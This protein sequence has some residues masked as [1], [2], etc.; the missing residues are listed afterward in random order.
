MKISFNWIKKYLQQTDITPQ[1]LSD[2]IKLHLSDIESFE[3][4]HEKYKNLLIGEIVKKQEHPNADKLGVYE[5]KIG[6][7]KAVQVVAGDK[8]LKVGD[9]VVYL[10]PKT[11]VPYNAYP[12]R[13]DG[14]IQKAKLRGIESNGMLASEK[15]LGISSDHDR[16]MTL[17]LECKAGQDVANVLGLN[18]YIFEVENKTLTIRPDTFGLIG[19]SRDISGFLNLPFTTPDWLN[20]PS[21]IKPKE[22]KKEK[23]PLKILN[24]TQR[25]CP[26]YMAITMSDVQ[27]KPSPLWLKIFLSSL[28]IKPINNVVDITNYLMVLT[29]QPLHAFDY[30]KVIS[31]DL[32]YK[33][34]AI[35]TVRTAKMGE[36]LTTI[37]QKTRELNEK[38]VV[39]CDSQNPIA[40]GGVM[41][42]LETEIDKD[43]KNIIIESANFDLYN[44]RKTSMSLGLVTDAVTRFSKGQ[45]PNLC[46]PVLYKATE[47]IKEICNGEIASNAQDNYLELPKPH[48]L[49]FSIKYFQKHTNLKLQKNEI[50]QILSNIEIKEIATKDED[51]VTLEIPTYRQD[52][53]IPEDIH[54]EIARLHGYTKIELTLPT[55][56]ITSTPPNHSIEF[57][58]TLRTILKGLG[59]NELLTYNFT[60]EKHYK[61]CDLE[62]KNCYKIINP[63][64]PELEYMRS[65]LIPSLFEKVNLNIN[66]GYE[67]FVLFEINKIHNKLDFCKKEQLPLE[68]KVLSMIFTKDTDNLYYHIKYYLDYLLKQLK[69]QNLNYENLSNMKA[70]SL[71]NHIKII[72][73]MFD[74]NK[75]AIISSESNGQKIYLG[76]IGEPNLNVQKKLKLIQPVGILE[77]SLNKLRI[78]KK[79]KIERVNFSKYPKISQDLC[80]VLNKEIPYSILQERI[81]TILHR[82]KLNFM[83]QP[84][85]IYQPK[86][87]DKLKQTTIRLILQHKEKTLKEKDI[88]SIREI[89]EKDIKKS[90]GGKIKDKE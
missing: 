41:G 12:D 9:K 20:N 65:T 63:L 78:I 2:K 80:F 24:K 5:V 59:A 1:E 57:D 32:H 39:I 55:R 7:K 25:L 23:L 50:L 18:D 72:T 77:L 87:E 86:N 82:R 42:G 58:K 28:G 90:L 66:N 52:L 4:L 56:K 30:D 83:L 54:E 61:N 19:I 67:E 62:I 10:P 27:I 64:S 16:V 11:K 69:I 51:L 8:N 37:D 22:L 81:S 45:D 84:I 89:I 31:K 74:I 6:Q 34:K 46:E 43:T 75:S 15:E 49:T 29:G 79:Q 71:P 33:D 60:N 13:F 14:I 36:K 48:R 70:E 38:T 3:N 76:I 40:I 44:I 85:D 88:K 68:N 73:P 35:I 53:K 47:L 17:E 21:K 26:R